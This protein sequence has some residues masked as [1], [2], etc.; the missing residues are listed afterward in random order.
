MDLMAKS[1]SADQLGLN[2]TYNCVLKTVDLWEVVF[3]D[4]KQ[5]T[6]VDSEKQGPM[7]MSLEE[8]LVLKKTDRRDYHLQ[9]RWNRSD[10]YDLNQASALSVIPKSD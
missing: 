7:N 5:L 4:L 9:T 2:D 8:H 10:R 1:T 3:N 6:H